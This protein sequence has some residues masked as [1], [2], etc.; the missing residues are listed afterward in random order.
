MANGWPKVRRLSCIDAIS[1]QFVSTETT[2]VVKPLPL[3]LAWVKPG[4]ETPHS[5]QLDKDL[6]NF[7]G[8]R[9]FIL[10]LHSAIVVA[11]LANDTVMLA[12]QLGDTV[13]TAEFPKSDLK[14]D[15]FKDGDYR[16]AEVKPGNLII[17]LRNGKRVKARVHW[18]QHD[19]PSVDRDALA[20]RFGSVRALRRL[21]DGFA[22]SPE[23]SL[24]ANQH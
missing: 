11:V 4:D 6:S 22:R 10:A 16:Q 20:R 5:H 14:P 13:Y 24:I 8:R 21:F 9:V 17:K 12:V 18:V 3:K 15:G 19:H 7:V 1:V 2:T 23:S